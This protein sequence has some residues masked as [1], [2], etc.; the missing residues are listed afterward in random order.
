MFS[1][2]FVPV[3]GDCFLCLEDVPCVRDY[4]GA[5]CGG[6]PASPTG[7]QTFVCLLYMWVLSK[8]VGGVLRTVFHGYTLC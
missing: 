3:L 6:F 1:V 7:T 4:S 2:G 8:A 5:R